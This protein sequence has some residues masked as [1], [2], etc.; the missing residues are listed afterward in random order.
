MVEEEVRVIVEDLAT[1]NQLAI[2]NF[3][4]DHINYRVVVSLAELI[5]TL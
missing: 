4:E 5:D 2:D 1:L 3:N